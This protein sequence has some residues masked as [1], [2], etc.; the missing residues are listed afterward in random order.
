MAT[1]KRA[2]YLFRVSEYSPEIRE[3]EQPGTLRI[4]PVPF[5]CTDHRGACAGFEPPLENGGFIFD[6]RPGTTMGQAKELA[7]LLNRHV[8]SLGTL[9]F[10]DAEDIIREVEISER[11]WE[12][13][14]EGLTEAVEA[15]E[16]KLATGDLAGAIQALAAVKGWA[17]RLSSDWG[18]TLIRFALQF[19]QD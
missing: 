3:G 9:T 5:I 18:R 12:N 14:E 19:V 16:A 6:L 15:L 8:E 1:N 2:R 11:N 7:D 17:W 4:A 10:G 13:V